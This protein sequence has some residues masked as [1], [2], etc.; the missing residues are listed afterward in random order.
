MVEKLRR[1]LGFYSMTNIVIGDIVGAGIFTTSGLL[2]A[3]LHDPLVLLILWVVGGIIA[4]TWALS[5][6][7]LGANFPQAGGD[8][9]LFNELSH[10]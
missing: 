7:E 10:H 3:Q 4:M 8:Y 6:G 1:K 2:L 9:I 5:Y